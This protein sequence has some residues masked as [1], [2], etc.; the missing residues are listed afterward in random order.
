MASQAQINEEKWQKYV[1]KL[2][3]AGQLPPES[4]TKGYRQSSQFWNTVDTEAN[5]DF[6]STIKE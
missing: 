2:A 6:E 5:R 4:V 3:K 1:A